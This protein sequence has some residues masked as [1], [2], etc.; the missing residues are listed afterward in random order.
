VQ[1]PVG[2]FF[3]VRSLGSDRGPN[4]HLSVSIFFQ[5]TFDSISEGLIVLIALCLNK[6]SCSDQRANPMFQLSCIMLAMWETLG[7]SLTPF[8]LLG[9][10][11][12]LGREIVPAV[13]WYQ[14]KLE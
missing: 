11:Y 2:L 9:R 10:L 13:T 5:P 14:T 3:Q 1:P 7:S 6:R 4:V 8:F 12:G